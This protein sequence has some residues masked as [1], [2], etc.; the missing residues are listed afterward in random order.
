[1]IPKADGTKLQKNKA[2]PGVQPRMAVPI[3]TVSAELTQ[4]LQW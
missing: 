1:M 4:S 2:S 3:Y